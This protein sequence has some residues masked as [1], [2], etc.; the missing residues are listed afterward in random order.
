[1]IYK[2]MYPAAARKLTCSFLSSMSGSISYLSK[3]DRHASRPHGLPPRE[4]PILCLPAPPQARSQTAGSFLSLASENITEDEAIE[5]GSAESPTA[6]S[7]PDPKPGN[8]NSLATI[9]EKGR[10]RSMGHSRQRPLL[11]AHETGGCLLLSLQCIQEKGFPIWLLETK[12]RQRRRQL[13]LR[14]RI[15]ERFL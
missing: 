5:A 13:D 3:L 8:A 2:R 7:M 6:D 4:W 12:E 15:L 1:M 10:G 11:A 9:P 14:H